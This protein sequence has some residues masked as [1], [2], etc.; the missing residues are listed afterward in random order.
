MSW[1][2]SIF[3]EKW[4]TVMFPSVQQILN[5]DLCSWKAAKYTL[6]GRLSRG[7]LME[8]TLYKLPN[9]LNS[10]SSE[11]KSKEYPAPGM[12]E[13]GCVYEEALCSLTVFLP[14]APQEVVPETQHTWKLHNTMYRSVPPLIPKTKTSLL[15]L[16]I[17]TFLFVF[18]SL[19]INYIIADEP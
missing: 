14:W 4:V 7:C 19:Q 9:Q 16:E 12:G 1:C 18:K 3:K 11:Q 13:G 5:C 2:L 17:P 6:S 10:P 15:Q 8:T